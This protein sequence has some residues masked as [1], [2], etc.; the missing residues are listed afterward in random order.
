MHL[1][2]NPLRKI[3]PGAFQGLGKLEALHLA[4]YGFTSL[5]PGTFDGLGALDPPSC[6]DELFI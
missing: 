1:R 5:Q 4:G 6:R 2:G 3:S